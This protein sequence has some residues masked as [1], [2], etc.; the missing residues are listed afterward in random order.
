MRPRACW[1][2]TFTSWFFNTSPEWVA[3]DEAEQ[4]TPEPLQ[5]QQSEAALGDAP[6]GDGVEPNQPRR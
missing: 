4:R 5:M 2:N 6:R 3:A 1:L